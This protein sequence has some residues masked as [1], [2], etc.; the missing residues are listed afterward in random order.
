MDPW[1]H[2]PI[3]SSTTDAGRVYDD[4]TGHLHL[5]LAGLAGD[6]RRDVLGG[7]LPQPEAVPDRPGLAHPVATEGA[8][9]VALEVEGDEVPAHPPV[10]ES[11]GLDPSLGG[12]PGVVGVGE[13]DHL[14]VTRGRGDHREQLALD[15]GGAPPAG[16]ADGVRLQRVDPPA[17]PLGQHLEQLGQRPERGLLH[18]VDRSPA[19]GAQR[20]RDGDRLVVVEQ[21][22]RHRRAGGEAVAAD[23]SAGGEH[24]VAELAQPLDVV[25]HRAL[26]DAEPSGELGA[27][28]FA[29]C[30]QQREQPQQASGGL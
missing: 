13:P 2:G 5:H 11:V 20:D 3:R 26:G 21:Q 29:R 18:P 25:A 10:D 22:R 6:V 17:E 28:P 4:P 14:A 12:G 19:G 7:E 8:P 1:V 16:D 15:V 30:L 24:R 23:R 27:G 9:V